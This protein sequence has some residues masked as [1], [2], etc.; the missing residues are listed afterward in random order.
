LC[1]PPAAATGPA[2]NA[3]AVDQAVQDALRAWEVPGAAVAIV[4]DDAVVY[5]KG[6]GVRELG[7]DDPVTPDTVFPIASCTK[8]FTTAAMAILVD[9]G[10]M[11]W[12]GPVREYIP[13][14]H[15]SDPLADSQV[16]LRD[17]VSHRTGVGPHDFLWYRAAWPQEEAIRRIGRVKAEYPFR[18]SFSYQTT[19]FT[20]AGHAVAAAAKMPWAEFVRERLLDPL[21]LKH[22]SL[23]T[24]DALREPDH[25]SPH[26]PGRSARLEVIPWYKIEV[27]EPAGS[28]NASAR[29]LSRWVRFQ[30]GDGTFEGKRL[31]SA[32]SLGETHTPQNIIRL[33]GQARAMNP[34]T[35]QMSYGMAWVI[36][37]HRG[38]LVWE[39]AGLIDGFQ[40]HLTL[41]PGAHLGLV[42]LNNRHQ[43]RMNLALSNTLVELLLDLPRRDWNDYF[44]G[45]LF[46]EAIEG[47]AR[48]LAP[49]AQR[50]PRTEPSREPAEYT[51]TYEEPAY[52]SAEVRLE[53]GSLVW[54]WGAFTC[55]L[56]HDH[57]D[58]FTAES[59]L[60]GDPRLLFTP[61][62]DGEVA[63]LRVVDLMGVEFRKV[64]SRAP[65]DRAEG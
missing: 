31:V 57:D 15:L 42:L 39:H 19:M 55:R 10:K 65:S 35:L 40:A 54:H 16:T 6:F 17:L 3:G 30:L 26:R 52:G 44:R 28:I 46:P 4:R 23:T 38:R 12:D 56:A 2:V 27:P 50:R 51:G 1:T 14:F 33:E 8:A 11:A 7:H 45:A 22:V 29:D 34:E 59:D 25:A 48:R 32:A 20:A 53:D 62:P 60:L 58:T 43:S 63:A 47:R 37:D 21:G 61:G 9:E 64:K 41:V 24:A 5:L 13:Y 49:A 18:A 36:R